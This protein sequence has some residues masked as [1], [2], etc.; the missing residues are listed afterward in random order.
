MNYGHIFCLPIFL[1][2]SLAQSPSLKCKNW[3][4]VLVLMLFEMLEREL[5]GDILDLF[6]I[7]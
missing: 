2:I 1:P 6:R 5:G 3:I 7:S 4:L